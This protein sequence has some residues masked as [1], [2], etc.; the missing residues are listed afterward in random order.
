MEK[1]NLVQSLD[2]ISG[3]IWED[4]LRFLFRDLMQNC[5][6]SKDNKYMK[7]SSEKAYV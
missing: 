7:I 5:V 2:I 1:Q 6:F 3:E 4:I